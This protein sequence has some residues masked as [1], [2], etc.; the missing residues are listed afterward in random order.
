MSALTFLCFFFNI[1]FLKSKL[2]PV[3]CGLSM[4]GKIMIWMYWQWLHD[5][6]GPCCPMSPER[7]LN[8]ITHSLTQCWEIILDIY[9]YI[10][11][12]FFWKRK[13]VSMTLSGVLNHVSHLSGWHCVISH[14]SECWNYLLWINYETKQAPLKCHS[15]GETCF[16]LFHVRWCHQNISKNDVKH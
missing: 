13:N 10:Y 2:W 6:H 12:C 1:F 8:L 14:L 3:D 15:L 9:V 11:L 7:P 4:W 16:A 5:L